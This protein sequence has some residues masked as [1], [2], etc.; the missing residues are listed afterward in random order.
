[1]IFTHDFARPLARPGI[2]INDERERSAAHVTAPTGLGA[3]VAIAG[4]RGIGDQGTRGGANH[5]AYHCTAD[6]MRSNTAN[7]GAGAAADQRATRHAIL[8]IRLTAGQGQSHRSH[9]QNLFHL[10]PPLNA[11]PHTTE[12]PARILV[13]GRGVSGGKED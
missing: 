11:N 2:Q 12:L 4:P 5:A 9:Q 7:D 6:R 13:P 10:F 1:L 8:P 3:V